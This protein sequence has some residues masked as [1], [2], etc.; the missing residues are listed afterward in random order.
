MEGMEVL[1]SIDDDSQVG[2]PPTKKPVTKSAL[3]ILLC[4]EDDANNVTGTLSDKRQGF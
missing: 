2:E 3:D 1:S 4:P